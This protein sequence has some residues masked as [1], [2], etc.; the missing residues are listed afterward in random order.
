MTA[1]P[2]IPKPPYTGG[3]LCRAVRYELLAWPLAVNARHCNDCKKTSGATNVLMLIAD[4]AAFSASGETHTYLSTA[5]SGLVKEI[6]RCAHCGVRV[7]HQN[8]ASPALVFIAAGTLDDTSWV[9][10]A[11][12]I[13]GER[14][15]PGVVMQADAIKV[16]GQP[17]DRNILMD[18]FTKIY[19]AAP[20]HWARRCP[21]RPSR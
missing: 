8:L 11:S 10:P 19:G 21:R 15:S 13:W 9:I 18:A 20:L 4:S 3:C 17:T 12:H 1:R 7:W 2:P 14:A 6:K 16:E 5:D